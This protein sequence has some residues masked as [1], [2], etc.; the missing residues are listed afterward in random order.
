VREERA[1]E[2][3]RLLGTVDA[4]KPSKHDLGDEIRNV[5]VACPR[6][7]AASCGSVRYVPGEQDQLIWLKGEPP[8]VRA[9]REA[10]EK[11]LERVAQLV[12]DGY[13]IEE[14]VPIAKAEGWP[15][16]PEP[17]SIA[18]TATFSCCRSKCRAIFI[19][20]RMTVNREL[21]A[22]IRRSDKTVSFSDARL[23]V[24]R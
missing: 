11:F 22:A 16:M 2:W 18:T 20:S 14:M 21:D 5:S 1:Q 23:V 3:S 9:E 8:E 15:I 17:S 7:G 6:C 19:V 13:S 12:N 24:S 4:D 10:T